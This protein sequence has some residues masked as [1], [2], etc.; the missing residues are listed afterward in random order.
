M[1]D[2]RSEEEQVQALK[3]WWKENGKSLLIGIVFAVLIVAAWKAWQQRSQQQ[4]EYASALYQNL[5]EAVVGSVSD[6]ADEASLSTARHLG[7]QL[8]TEFEGSAYARMAAL[9]MARLAVERNELDVALAELD[10]VQTHEPTAA[11]AVVVKLRKARILAAQ[12][13]VEQG[14]QLLDGLANA[15]FQARIDEV[16]GD[17]YLQQ[18]DRDNARKAYQTALAA[19]SSGAANPLLSVKLNDLA[20]EDK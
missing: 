15:A 9:L 3:D 16:R 6:Q 12:G 4:A 13:N 10:W 8:K 1:A 5:L 20:V 11:Q 17:L 14:L 2:L 19:G 7:E 18:G